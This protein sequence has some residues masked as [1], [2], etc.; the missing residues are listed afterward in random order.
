MEEDP[1]GQRIAELLAGER[2]GRLV[3]AE[4]VEL[5]LYREEQPELVAAARVW[6]EKSPIH[7][8]GPVA[9]D[10]AWLERI[11]A[12]QALEAAERAPRTRGERAVG[13][14]LVAGGWALS[15]VGWMGGSVMLV[16][17]IALLLGSFIRVRLARRDPYD[18]IKQ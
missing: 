14:A 9:D 4:S 5:A 8:L 16:V 2:E 11:R 17:G 3:A 13:L 7:G 18:R 10:G 6:V 12:G 1:E 15:L